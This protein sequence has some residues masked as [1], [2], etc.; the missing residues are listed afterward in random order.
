VTSPVEANPHQNNQSEKEKKTPPK[1]RNISIV[2]NMGYYL[3][4]PIFGGL[5]LGYLLDR[6]LNTKPW[7][8]LILMVLGIVAGLVK[9][10]QLAMKLGGD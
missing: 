3:V 10:I 7:F 5:F 9:T 6:W 4:G 2:I 1:W 8:T